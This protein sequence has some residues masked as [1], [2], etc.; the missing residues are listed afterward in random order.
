MKNAQKLFGSG[1][2]FNFFYERDQKQ[3]IMK[4]FI[5]RFWSISSSNSASYQ[6]RIQNSKTSYTTIFR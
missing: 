4:N 1:Y 3:F 2:L 6:W 5:R